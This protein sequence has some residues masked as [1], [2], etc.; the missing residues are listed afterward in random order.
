[1]GKDVAAALGKGVCYARGSAEKKGENISQEK[2]FTRLAKKK[3]KMKRE[4]YCGRGGKTSARKKRGEGWL[5]RR[6][7][8]TNSASKAGGRSRQLLG[9]NCRKILGD[10]EKR[11]LDTG[12]RERNEG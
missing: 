5:R 10:G 12:T 8:K 7:V 1:L 4:R 11:E 6:G 2:P 3:K 9:P